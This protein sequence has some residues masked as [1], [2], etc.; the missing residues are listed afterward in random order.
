MIAKRLPR[1]HCKCL[2]SDDLRRYYKTAFPALPF[3]L[4]SFIISF[5]CVSTATLTV[6]YAHGIRIAELASL[7]TQ[8]ARCSYQNDS[9]IVRKGTN[10]Y[11][12]AG[13]HDRHR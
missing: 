2:T 12:L 5:N 4:P 3:A 9:S 11:L 13:Y 10:T 6:D 8:S 7:E 1:E